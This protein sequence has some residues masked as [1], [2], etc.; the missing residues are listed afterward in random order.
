MDGSHQ[1]AR[2][3]RSSRP[4]ACARRG[5]HAPRWQC[6]RSRP[7]SCS[8]A[9]S[10]PPAAASTPRPAERSFSTA[11]T[12]PTRPGCAAGDDRGVRA[13]GRHS[14]SVRAPLSGQPAEGSTR[15]DRAFGWPHGAGI[16][17][18]CGCGCGC[19]LVCRRPSRRLGSMD[20]EST[21]HRSTRDQR[22]GGFFV[23]PAL[24]AA[25]KHSSPAARRARWWPR[26]W[27]RARD[28][29]PR[30]QPQ[31]EREAGFHAAA[32][33]HAIPERRDDRGGPRGELRRCATVRPESLLGVVAAAETPSA[34]RQP[35]ALPIRAA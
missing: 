31:P 18:G 7:R 6:R 16:A 34:A 27:A 11:H 23:I 14:V 28:A 25:H 10:R 1:N 2:A 4:N 30:L 20:L 29:Q 19:E 26:R 32:L 5:A 3:Q 8:S 33:E 9:A 17:C 15:R 13:L 21:F 35:A 12:T 24:A 22:A